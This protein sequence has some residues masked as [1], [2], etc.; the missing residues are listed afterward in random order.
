L[1]VPGNLYLALLHHP[2]YDKNRDV[3]VSAVSNLDLHD[4]ARA[5]KTYGARTLYIVTPLLDQQELVHRIVSHWTDGVGGRYNPDRKAALSLIRVVDSLGRALE[6]AER[7]GAGLPATVVTDANP[8]RDNIGFERLQ[9]LLATGRPHM[10][11][12]GTAWGLTR[13]FIEEV[14]YILSPI[15]GYTEY[16]HLSVRSAAAIVLDRLLGRDRN[17]SGGRYGRN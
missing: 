17:R 4:I 13:E 2:V 16:N 5:A 9:D 15:K 14:D 11:L 3:I 1:T 10:L 8:H 6:D 12:F 7:D